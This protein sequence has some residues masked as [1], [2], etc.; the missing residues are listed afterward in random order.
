M[1]KLLLISFSFLFSGALFAQGKKCTPEIQSVKV[2]TVDENLKLTLEVYTKCD[3]MAYPT[4]I[5]YYEG[6]PLNKPTKEYYGHMNGTVQ[7]YVVYIPKKYQNNLD[8]IT[9]KLTGSVDQGTVEMVK[10]EKVDVQPPEIQKLSSKVEGEQLIIDL[11]VRVFEH[12]GAYPSI[13]A[14]LDGAPLNKPALDYYAQLAN[15]TQPYRISVPAKYKDDVGRITYKMAGASGSELRELTM[16]KRNKNARPS[17]RE[18]RRL[19]SPTPVKAC[20][21]QITHINSYKTEGGI[22]LEL[23]VF[24]DCEIK[25]NVHVVAKDG[26]KQVSALSPSQRG[27][28]VHAA[29]KTQKYKIV[30]PAEYA[31]DISSLSFELIGIEG[32][33]SL[34]VVLD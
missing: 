6:R 32:K 26:G 22:E 5:A 9:F 2:D 24:T 20:K 15:T 23:D 29:E 31:D 3:F 30:L 27:F 33:T 8:D 16:P 21:S 18:E 28:F 11:D 12:F 34:E 17:L 19:V 25:G 7:P 10:K 14:Y 13:I 4:A 1:K